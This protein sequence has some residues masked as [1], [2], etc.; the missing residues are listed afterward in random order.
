MRFLFVFSNL[1]PLDTATH[2]WS[3]HFFLWFAGKQIFESDNQIFTGNFFLISWS[4]IIHLS[5]VN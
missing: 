1:F 4:G 3:L 5:A 2:T